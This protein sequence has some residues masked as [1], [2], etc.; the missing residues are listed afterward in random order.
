VLGNF[1]RKDL[2]SYF[3]D[4]SSFKGICCIPKRISKSK[5]S[6]DDYYL[7]PNYCKDLLEYLYKEI[8]STNSEFFL[9]IEPSCE[10]VEEINLE[11]YTT[12]SKKTSFF[13]FRLIGKPIATNVRLFNGKKQNNC[14]IFGDKKTMI[15][16]FTCSIISVKF[17]TIIP[18][19]LLDSKNCKFDAFL[20]SYI[21]SRFKPLISYNDLVANISSINFTNLVKVL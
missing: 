13:N 3:P 9:F 4:L 18:N 16:L 7:L 12:S 20:I 5:L 14:F 1:T 2:L 10:I 15:E 8:S 11:Q 21:R 6:Q 17:L 19:Y